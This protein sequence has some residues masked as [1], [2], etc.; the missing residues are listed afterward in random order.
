MKAR[1]GIFVLVGM[2]ALI[3]AAAVASAQDIE[4]GLTYTCNGERIYIDSCNMQDTSDASKCFIGHPDT[5]MPNGLMKY[6]YM[7]RGEMKK[8]L[9]TCKAP[10]PEQLAKVRA[11]NKKVNDS[12]AAAQKK[13]ED[14]LNAQEARANAQIQAIANGNKKPQTP[15]ERAIARCLTSGRLA[16]SCT[17]NALLGAFTQM[18]SQVLPTAGK[19][20]TPG[21]NM[22]GV[23]QGAGGWRLD[24]VDDGVLVNCASLSP[25]QRSYR[26][27]FKNDRTSLVIDTTPKPLVLTL[28]ADGTIVGPGPVTI[29]GVVATGSSGG[30]TGYS[31]NYRD[32]NGTL[33]T[34]QAAAS[35]GGAYDQAGNQIYVNPSAGGGGPSFAH[36]TA[37]CPAL[38]LS[39]KGAGP[40]IQTMETDLLKTA[41]GGDKGP[42][43]PPGIRMHGIYAAS[44]GFSV[45]FFPESAVLGCGPDAA[46]AYPY[47]VVAD[48]TK[49]VIRVAAPDH[50]LTLAYNA[51]GSL[52]PGGTGAYQVHGRTITGQNDDGDFTFA[53]ME[54]ACNLAVLRAS[55]TIPANSGGGATTAGVAANG[56]GS[57]SR[58]AGSGAAVNPTGGA[59]NAV[60][61]LASGFSAPAGTQNPV[62]GKMFVL[63]RDNFDNV[64]ANGGF[65]VPAGSSPYIA[66]LRACTNRTPDCQK[67]SDAVNASAATGGRL[68]AT[69]HGTFAAVAP[70][71]YWIMGAGVVAGANPADRKML[72]WN[73]RVELRPGANSVTLDG[74]NG[75]VVHP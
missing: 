67:A 68:D 33:I 48:G 60:L 61:T 19:D 36:R 4:P 2:L 35:R 5:I 41:F 45:Q 74:S 26:L 63:L 6:T 11:F 24:F 38:N 65:A 40:G 75:A 55:K 49:A 51:D 31:H 54:Q 21:P 72:F 7:T 22:A 13:A 15:E 9:P 47:S 37:T 58:A 66:M 29:D 70:G 8:V 3:F 1:V 42:P 34:D 53:P 57:A 17:G 71:T 12:Q 32:E 30:D 52:D 59:A 73:V 39:S 16:A 56:G 62:A 27:E 44:T 50:P 69:G 20:P 25:D 43:T 10:T 23:Y 28:R 18:V 46:R 14:D 64:L